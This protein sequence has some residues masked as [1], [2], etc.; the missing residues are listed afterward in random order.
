[1]PI[2]TDKDRRFHDDNGDENDAPASWTIGVSRVENGFIC[3]ASDG[4]VDVF[5]E[6]DDSELRPDPDAIA[7][8]LY[9]IVEYFGATGTKHD[10]RRV[11]V[12]VEPGSDYTGP[13]PIKN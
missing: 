2:D 4:R 6:S 5:E 3:E 7:R 1:M 12:T 9:R 11:S 13:T 8:V 10:A